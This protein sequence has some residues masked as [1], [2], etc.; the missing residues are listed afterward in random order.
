[1]RPPKHNGVVEFSQLT[2]RKISALLKDAVWL[3]N[4]K[5]VDISVHLAKPPELTKGKAWV[6][7]GGIMKHR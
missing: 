5:R 7:I 2:Y 4:D 3:V 1:M 6:V